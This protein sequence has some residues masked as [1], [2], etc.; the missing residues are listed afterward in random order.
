MKHLVEVKENYFKHLVEAL[1]ISLTLIVASIACAIHA[2]FP[3]IFKKTASTIM[4]NILS[5]TDHR[6]DR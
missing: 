6:Y 3:F 1:W 5:R 4:R 2:I